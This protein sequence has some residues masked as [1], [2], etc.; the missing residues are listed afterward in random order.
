M[1]FRE[2]QNTTL[3]R[4]YNCSGGQLHRA[5]TLLPTVPKRHAAKHEAMVKF[6][7]FFSFCFPTETMKV[8]K[9]LSYN[10]GFKDNV[11]RHCTMS[12]FPKEI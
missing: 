4:V 11:P 10:L 3:L 8:N 6:R 7:H 12:T 2:I 1:P 9:L 5:I